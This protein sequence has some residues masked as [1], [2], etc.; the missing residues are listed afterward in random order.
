MSYWGVAVTGASSYSLMG[1]QWEEWVMMKKV[2]RQG[3]CACADMGWRRK[4][5][6]RVEKKKRAN[7]KWRKGENDEYL[8]ISFLLFLE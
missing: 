2:E 1:K 4:K 6:V 5:R 8:R 3:M 7:A